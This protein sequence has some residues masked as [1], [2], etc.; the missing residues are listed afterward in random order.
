[1][2]TRRDDADWFGDGVQGTFGIEPWG[3]RGEAVAVAG[4]HCVVKGGKFLAM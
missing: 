1:M 2:Y 3:G 4:G